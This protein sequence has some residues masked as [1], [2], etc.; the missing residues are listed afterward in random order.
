VHELG[1]CDAILD[2]TLK[3][4]AGR[5]VREVRVRVGGHP[6]DPDVINHGVQVAA[7]GTVA[8]GVLVHVVNEPTT[9]HCRAC[10]H[11]ASADE[12]MALVACSNC[13]GLDIDVTGTEHVVLESLTVDAPVTPEAAGSR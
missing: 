2:A 13:G 9:L 3:R 4:A 8:E 10:G 6:V 1:L 12:P 5:R 7:V 11:S